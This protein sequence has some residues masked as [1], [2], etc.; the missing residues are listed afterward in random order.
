MGLLEGPAAQIKVS[1]YQ[2]KNRG[3]SVVLEMEDP[4]F[5]FRGFAPH[6]FYVATQTGLDV[7]SN[8]IEKISLTPD[9]E[10]IRGP[11]PPQTGPAKL[12]IE[13][14]SRKTDDALK[15]MDNMYLWYNFKAVAPLLVQDQ[16][17]A[18]PQVVPIPP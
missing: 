3:L 2:V 15:A 7:V 18:E 10:A 11:I 12:Y 8:G 13:F 16:V 1:S 6:S 17:N 14:S 4:Q 5:K 9:G